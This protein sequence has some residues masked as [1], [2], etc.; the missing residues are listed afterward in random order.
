[1]S[2]LPV[3]F[4]C[5]LSAASRPLNH[6]WEHTVGS[7]HA[8]LALRADWQDQLR[9]CHDELGFRHVR[10]HGPLDDDMGTLICHQDELLWLR[11]TRTVKEAASDSG[12]LELPVTFRHAER[13]TALPPHHRDPFDRMLVAQA[14]VEA[15]ALFTRDPVFAR[16][17]VALVEA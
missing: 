16:Y 11:P 8:L 5:D 6:A 10:F 9:R 13:M 17:G 1:M 3:T 2:D 15:L 7:G 4:T 12:F 14:A